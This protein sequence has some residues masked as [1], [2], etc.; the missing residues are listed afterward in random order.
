MSI[1][2]HDAT[3]YAELYS[4]DVLCALPSAPDQTTKTGIQR[5][6]DRSSFE[7][8]PQPEEF[9]VL[10]DSAY[11][12]VSVDGLLAHRAD[13]GEPGTSGL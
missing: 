11:A 13:G 10:G 7:V 8:H 2:V 6:F 5:L 9:E 3:A 1:G 12:I 4:E